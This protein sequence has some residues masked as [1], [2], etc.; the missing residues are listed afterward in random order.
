MNITVK[1]SY[2]HHIESD[3]TKE[4]DIGVRIMTIQA[5]AQALSIKPNSVYALIAKGKVRGFKKR[6]KFRPATYI[7]E[8]DVKEYLK[9]LLLPTYGYID[10]LKKNNKTHLLK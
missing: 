2:K 6:A 4:K 10:Y 7:P 5:V 9:Q 8:V 1:K 3:W